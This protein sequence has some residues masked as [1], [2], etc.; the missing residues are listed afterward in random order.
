MIWEDCFAAEDDY[1]FGVELSDVLAAYPWLAIPSQSVLCVADGEGRNSVHL[2]RRGM[3]VTA[4]D[5]SA[6]AVGRATELGRT[7]WR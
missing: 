4:F 2:A 7:G 1:L 6:T 5:L 3:N